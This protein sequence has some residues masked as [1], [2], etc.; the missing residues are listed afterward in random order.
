MNEKYEVRLNIE[1][2]GQNQVDWTFSCESE[3]EITSKVDHIVT[4]LTKLREGNFDWSKSVV[5]K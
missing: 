2:Y 1:L 5:K 3:Q 4:S